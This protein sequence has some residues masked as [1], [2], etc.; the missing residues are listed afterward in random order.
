M[1]I[2]QRLTDFINEKCVCDNCTNYRDFMGNRVCYFPEPPQHIMETRPF[3]SCECNDLND[4]K[5]KSELDALMDEY[6]EKVVKP[7]LPPDMI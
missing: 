4:P 2:D 1:E 3:D 5:I 6:Y 7:E